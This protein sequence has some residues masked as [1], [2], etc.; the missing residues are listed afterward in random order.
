MNSDTTTIDSL[1]LSPQSENIR[2]NINDENIA[3]HNPAQS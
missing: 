2:M 1:P 3:V